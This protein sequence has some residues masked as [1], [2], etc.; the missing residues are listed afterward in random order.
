MTVSRPSISELRRIADSYG[1]D[2][3]DTELEDFSLVGDST[4][5]SYD[6]LDL[7]QAPTLPVKYPRDAGWEPTPEENPHNAWAWRC[8]VK[9]ADSGKLKDR[10]IALKDNICLAGMPLRN[11]SAVLAGFIPNEDATVVTRILDAG[12]EIVGK[13]VCENFCFSGGSHTSHG[14]PVHNPANPAHSTGGSSSGS[15]AL[16]AAGSADMALGGDQGGSIRIPSSWCGIVGLKPTYGLVPY[17]GIFPIEGTLDHTGPMTKTVADAALLLEVIAGEDG[18]DPRQV[19]VRTARYTEALTGEL[20]G[21]R[22]AVVKEG[23]GWEG[24]S[25]QVVD[26]T[27]GAAVRMITESGANVTEVSIPIHR[28][29][30]HIW[31]GIAVEGA[32]AQMVRG[33]AMGFN[34]RGH[35]S[36][37]MRDSYGRARRARANDFPTTVKL[38]ALLGQYMSDRYNGHYYAKAQNLGRTLRAAYDAA[39][40][41]ADVLVMPTMPM[42]AM[43][44]P[45][46]PDLPTYFSAALGMLQNTSPFDITGHPAITVPCGCADGLPIGMMLVG[47]HF[48]ESTVLRAAHAY[49]QKRVVHTAV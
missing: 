17:T 28:D 11:G 3:S 7:L 26:E 33:D 36:L 16:V 34:W 19:N 20:T 21:L 38:V 27:V 37:G 6:R 32:T 23:F 12:G 5:A 29:G 43:L 49:E 1:F 42:R 45:E 24:V 15:G 48:D 31:N 25:E 39:L 40:A 14:G 10:T 46:S 9:G 35:Y 8:S 18:L 4:L 13:A 22:V 41:E 47:R 2:L 44:I 30:I